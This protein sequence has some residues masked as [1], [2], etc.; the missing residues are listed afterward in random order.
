MVWVWLSGQG[1]RVVNYRSWDRILV[2][3]EYFFAFSSFFSALLITFDG[4]A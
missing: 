3:G 4:V 2:E 1:R